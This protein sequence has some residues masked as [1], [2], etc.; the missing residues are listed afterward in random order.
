[1][2]PEQRK[3]ALSTRISILLVA[4]WLV[5]TSGLY[6]ALVLLELRWNLYDWQPRYDLQGDCLVCGTGC[7]IYV[8][9]LLAKAGGNRVIRTVSFL[10]CLA[11]L[12]LGV[13]IMP[14]EPL[15]AG[16]FGREQ[17]SPSWYR[18]ARTLALILPGIFWSLNRAPGRP[19]TE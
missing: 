17:S 3:T 4:G 18:G 12:A 9:W 10:A 7:L 13:Y 11:L 5:A 16:V 19:S 2:H 15:T 8:F 6:V 14:P 1:M